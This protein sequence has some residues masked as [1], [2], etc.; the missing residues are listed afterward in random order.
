MK[1]LALILSVLS[2][3]V[4]YEEKSP[5]PAAEPPSYVNYAPEV[6]WAEA[7]CYWDAYYRDYIWYFEADANDPN[8]VYDV[9]SVWA[10]VYDSYNGAWQD[11][12]ELFPT[13][14]PLTWF[15]D[16]LGSTTYLSCNY[17]GYVVDIVAYDSYDIETVATI[18]PIIWY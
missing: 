17:P 5:P 6:T 4:V 11:S 1:R 12:F 18:D 15:S 10:D 16:W 7:G 9:V 2:G 14:D 13:D 3:C 8:G